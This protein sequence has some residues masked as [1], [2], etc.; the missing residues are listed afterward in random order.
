MSV[1]ICDMC[2]LIDDWGDGW[3]SYGSL[4]ADDEGLPPLKTCSDDC[5]NTIIDPD[6]AL[7]RL[8]KRKGCRVPPAIMKGFRRTPA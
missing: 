8:W 7:L 3:Q 2:G 6:L 1:H 5:R 4:L